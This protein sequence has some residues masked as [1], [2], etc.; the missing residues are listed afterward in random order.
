MNMKLAFFPFLILIFGCSHKPNADK[1]TAL[2]A[3]ASKS[4]SSDTVYKD[5]KTIIIKNKSSFDTL[6]KFTSN[7]NDSLYFVKFQK[8]TPKEKLDFSRFKYGQQFI[9]RTKDG[10]IE[11]GLNFA[12]HYSFVYWGCGS[13]CKLSAVVDL[14]TGIVYNGVI[15]EIGY[16]CSPNSRVLVVNP[17]DSTG[18]Y[19]KNIAWAIPRQFV[20][21]GQRFHELKN[22][23]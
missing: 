6:L 17:P 20:W 9:T 5:T 23:N 16:L 22:F 11:K 1:Q 19:N 4:V 8:V 10:V 21:D 7:L 12:G 18:W 13:P 14:R 15:S 3:H 2:K